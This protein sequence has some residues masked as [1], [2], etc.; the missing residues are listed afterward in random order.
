MLAGAFVCLL[1]F[2][3]F[4][5]RKYKKPS[6]FPPGPPSLPLVGS[7]PFLPL[8]VLKREYRLYDYLQKDFGDISGCMYG[9]RPIIAVSDPN[10]LRKLFKLDECAGRKPAASLLPKLRYGHQDGECRGIIF[11]NGEEWMEQR[12]FT[13]RCLKDHGFGKISMEDSI[14]RD[15]EK[16]VL[17][18]EAEPEGKALNLDTHLKVTIVN[19]LWALLVGEELVLDDP[20]LL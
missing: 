3:I 1:F 5:W 7:L 2:T 19:A 6:G 4:L 17:K 13:L 18:L 15:V 8:S 14:T 16:L 9:K 12:R 20:K 11:S 10:V